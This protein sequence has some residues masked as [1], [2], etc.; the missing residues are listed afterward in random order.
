MR[1]LSVFLIRNVFSE[2]YNKIKLAYFISQPYQFFLLLD[3]GRIMSKQA[4]T[5]T[6]I[7]VCDHF[8]KHFDSTTSSLNVWQTHVIKIK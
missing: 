3:M 4:K 5:Q 2:A 6:Y 8:F 7:A 1:W